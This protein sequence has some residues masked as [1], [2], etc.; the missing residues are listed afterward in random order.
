VDSWD[1]GYWQGNARRTPGTDVF[2][3]RWRHQHGIEKS[4]FM[5]MELLDLSLTIAE[6]SYN[7]KE[8]G[9]EMVNKL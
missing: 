8:R 6:D 2:G 9:F 4:S 5:S 7:A 1:S 3:S